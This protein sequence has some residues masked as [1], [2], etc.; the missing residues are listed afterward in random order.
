MGIA[1]TTRRLLRRVVTD[2]YP[3]VGFRACPTTL[4]AWHKAEDADTCI[5]EPVA[6]IDTWLALWQQTPPEGAWDNFPS[7]AIGS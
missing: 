5:Q 7:V 1:T 2:C 3:K 6:Q 4:L